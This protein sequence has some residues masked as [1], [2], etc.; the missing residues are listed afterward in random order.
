[1]I[2]SAHFRLESGQKNAK[3][4]AEGRMRRF[5]YIDLPG[6]LLTP[7]IS[8]L[9]SAIHEYRGKQTLYVTAKK[10]VLQNLLEIA[11]IQS[12]DSSNR[13]EGIYT[14]DARLKELVMQ[15]AEPINRN[16]KEIAGYRDVLRTIHENYEYIPITPNSILQL[17]RDLYSF[18]PSGMGG[19]WKNADN[20][21]AETDAAGAKRIRFTPTPAFETP[22][23][24]RSLCDAYREAVV[25]ERCDPLMLLVIFIFDFLCVHP[26]NDGNGRMS[27]LLT[28]MLLYQH[29]YI[30]GKYISIEKLIEENKQ[31][32]YEALQASSA[33]WETGQNNY[34]PFLL[35]L[36]GI[37]LKSYREFESRVEHIVTRK[38]GKADRV[39][40]IFDQKPGKI[41]KA[42]IVRF[43]PDISLSFIE[44][45]LKQMLEIGDIKKIGAG[46]ATA[47]IKL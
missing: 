46:R 2:F 18:H 27:R 6:A 40:M 23:A 37:I 30:V 1:M 26:F 7:E 32:Y 13:I 11:V 16:E 17:H 8:N 22:E 19:H 34:M 39:R 47:Y 38:L 20:L 25:L 36:L 4:W 24:M 31:S 33:D 15:K 44:R 10:D 29:G 28:L 3:V 12:T 9:L 14:S 21:I 35:Y 42:D 43:C 41:S 45:T 5:N